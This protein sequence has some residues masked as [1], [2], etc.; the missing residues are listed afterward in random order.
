MRAFQRFNGSKAEG[1][2]QGGREWWGSRLSGGLRRHSRRAGARLTDGQVRGCRVSEGADGLVALQG[3]RV[4]LEV[5][6]QQG[7]LLLE[8]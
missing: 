1:G 7:D 2:G 4:E 5:F 8:R 6:P 3:R